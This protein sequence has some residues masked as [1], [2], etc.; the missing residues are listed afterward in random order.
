MSFLCPYGHWSDDSIV[1]SVCGAKMSVQTEIRPQF[2]SADGANMIFKSL[3][4]PSDLSVAFQM[5]RA[6]GE[7]EGRPWRGR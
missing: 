7:R 3:A 6:P 4:A 2:G 5:A 1:C